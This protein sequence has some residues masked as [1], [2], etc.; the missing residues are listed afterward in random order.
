MTW[1]KLA[2][3]WTAE[4]APAAQPPTPRPQTKTA[5]YVAARRSLRE[6][7]SM[8]RTHPHLAIDLQS[9]I[10][11]VAAALGHAWD[12]H[13]NGRRHRPL[14]AAADVA[15]RAGRTPNREARRCHLRTAQHL[16]ST[17]RAI[18]L[19]G[20]V[21]AGDDRAAWMLVV[22]QLVSTL[23]ALGD[24]QRATQRADQA[25]AAHR[26]ATALRLELPNGWPRERTRLPAASSAPSGGFRARR[27]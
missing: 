22:H 8:L 5:A 2:T 23:Q 12:G 26:S 16:R 24:A 27:R 20:R 6:M 9:P 4:P 15:D 17:A 1:P 7:Q 19:A 11:D 25:A 3:R 10:A 18:A 13:H 21:A 14:T